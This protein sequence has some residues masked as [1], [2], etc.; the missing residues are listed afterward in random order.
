MNAR[1]RDRGAVWLGIVS[2]LSVGFVFIKRELHFVDMPKAG[3]AVAIVLGLM[4]IAGGWLASRVLTAV[5][6][7]GFLA[8]AIIQVVAQTAGES[9]ANGSNG[10]TL[11]LWLG[12]GAALLALGL[13]PRPSEIV[14]S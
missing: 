11:G 6:G 5:A 1:S 7:G 2:I 4:A 10:S 3:I 12:L 13:T 9:L 8:A 14:R